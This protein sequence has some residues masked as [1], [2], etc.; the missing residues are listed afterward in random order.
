MGRM[1]RVCSLSGLLPSAEI[2][3]EYHDSQRDGRAAQCFQPDIANEPVA[4][5]ACWLRQ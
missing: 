4:Q 3:R 2:L 5:S 1:E